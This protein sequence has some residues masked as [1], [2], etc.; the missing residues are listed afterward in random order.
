MPTCAPP[1]HR[2]APHRN[3]NLSTLCLCARA[4]VYSPDGI[5]FLFRIFAL[6]FCTPFYCLYINIFLCVCV[7]VVVLTFTMHV[8][9]FLSSAFIVSLLIWRALSS[10]LVQLI[11]NST[12]VDKIP[13]NRF[14]AALVNASGMLSGGSS[15]NNWYIW[16]SVFG[17]ELAQLWM[18]RSSHASVSAKEWKLVSSIL[19]STTFFPCVSSLCSVL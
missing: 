11:P 19:I 9:N 3:W 10:V 17:T 4:R 18:D 13:S 7:C 6:S 15:E 14:A 1:P 12:R 8:D 2:A 16:N 5:Q